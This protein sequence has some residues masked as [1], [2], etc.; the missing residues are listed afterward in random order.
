MES[1]MEVFAAIRRDARIES[2]STRELAR[3]HDVGRNMVK[4]A[5]HSASP[6]VRRTPARTA[7]RLDP[8]KDDNDE[9]LTEDLSA[10]RKQR[11]TAT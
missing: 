10:P 4:L 11:N 9:K 6:L 2:H 1:R 7:P 5:L 8:F 3:K